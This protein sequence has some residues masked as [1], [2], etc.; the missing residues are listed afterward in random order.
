MNATLTCLVNVLRIIMRQ[1]DNAAGAASTDFLFHERP[2]V[3]ID[4]VKAAIEE[5]V[6]FASRRTCDIGRVNDWG[7]AVVASFFRFVTM[8]CN[9]SRCFELGMT[10]DNLT[11]LIFFS[12]FYS[13]LKGYI[14]IVKVA[15]GNSFCNGGQH[16]AVAF[17]EYLC[18]ILA[19]SPWF[20][21]HMGMTSVEQYE[22]QQCHNKWN[23]RS[24][25][26]F[27]TMVDAEG[28]GAGEPEHDS[29]AVST[30]LRN[31]QKS[32]RTYE[33][34]GCSV[35]SPPGLAMVR[36]NIA[37]TQRS[38]VSSVLCVETSKLIYTQ[39]DGHRKRMTNTPIVDEAK[40]TLLNDGTEKEYAYAAS[41]QGV[42][43]HFFAN[44][45]Y[46]EG[47]SGEEKSLQRTIVNDLT[48]KRATN[49][50]SEGANYPQ[51]LIFYVRSST[52]PLSTSASSNS[53]SSSNASM[54]TDNDEIDLVNGTV[55]ISTG[56][57]L[58][59]HK[60][61]MNLRDV[62]LRDMNA[63]SKLLP[64]LLNA[65]D[66]YS[67]E[68][69]H[70]VN[71]A[72]SNVSR[73]NVLHDDASFV[74]DE[75]SIR[76]IASEIPFTP[77][78]RHL[79]VMLCRAA[80]DDLNALTE[81]QRKLL[82]G[83]MD[84]ETEASGS[85][86]VA[87]VNACLPRRDSVHIALPDA[88]GDIQ[89]AASDVSA[90]S[91]LDSLVTR[92]WDEEIFMNECIAY[93]LHNADNQHAVLVV[94]PWQ[95]RMFLF[96]SSSPTKAIREARAASS[97]T[98][99][100]VYYKA[101]LNF[102]KK[103]SAKKMLSRVGLDDGG[104]E[105][106][107][108]QPWMMTYMPCNQHINPT[109]NGIFAAFNLL[110]VVVQGQSLLPLREE[111][112][113]NARL[114]L[115]H[116][117]A[118]GKIVFPSLIK[119]PSAAPLQRAL[120]QLDPMYTSGHAQFLKDMTEQ[121]TVLEKL[122]TDRH[123]RILVVDESYH[124]SRRTG[125]SIVL[126]KNWKDDNVG[127]V[128]LQRT[129]LSGA[130]CFMVLAHTLKTSP[131]GSGSAG[132]NLT[133]GGNLAAPDAAPSA[134]KRSRAN[135]DLSA[136]A[137]SPGSPG[138]ESSS[139][140]AGPPR[141][142]LK[143]VAMCKERAAAFVDLSM[144]TKRAYVYERMELV[145]AD[146]RLTFATCSCHTSGNERGRVEVR[147]AY[148]TPNCLRAP[149]DSTAQE[150][151]GCPICCPCETCSNRIVAHLELQRS[152]KNLHDASTLYDLVD[153][154]IRQ[155]D[156]GL[157][158]EGF[159]T[160]A[161]EFSKWLGILRT[162]LKD[163]TESSPAVSNA[164]HSVSATNPYWKGALDL[165]D[166]DNDSDKSSSASGSH[167]EGA[168]YG[169]VDEEN[170]RLA[171]EFH[172]CRVAFTHENL[173][174]AYA[175]GFARKPYHLS[176]HS[177]AF[178][179][180]FVLPRGRLYSDRT[181]DASDYLLLPKGS[182][183][184]VKVVH[185]HRGR[186]PVVGRARLA[187]LPEFCLFFC[188]CNEE[189]TLSVRD[190]LRSFRSEIRKARNTTEHDLDFAVRSDTL[191]HLLADQVA[192]FGDFSHNHCTHTS[193]VHQY[194]AVASLRVH[195]GEGR[196]LSEGEQLFQRALLRERDLKL[197]RPKVAARDNMDIASLC[198][199]RQAQAGADI[200]MPSPS[201]R[202]V[203]PP[204]RDGHDAACAC[205]ECAGQDEP[206]DFEDGSDA[207]DEEPEGARIGFPLP[208]EGTAT[209]SYPAFL[210]M[211]NGATVLVYQKDGTN[212]LECTEHCDFSG[213]PHLRLVRNHA[214]AQTDVHK[215]ES[216]EGLN[217]AAKASQF[218]VISQKPR[219]IYI[220][221]RTHEK[222]PAVSSSDAPSVVRRSSDPEHGMCLCKDDL[223][224]DC[225]AYLPG[226]ELIHSKEDTKLAH[227]CKD[228]HVCPACTG[229]EFESS[230]CDGYYYN[231]GTPIPTRV[232]ELHCTREDCGGRVLYD[233]RRN[234]QFVMYLNRKAPSK[235]V[236]IVFS[237][238]FC[239]L[240][241]NLL[242]TSSA[243][244]FH[245]YAEVAA[246]VHPLT[247]PVD[248]E[249]RSRDFFRTA[250]K[251]FHSVVKTGEKPVCSVCLSNPP[252][253]TLDGCRNGDKAIN[254]ESLC[255]PSTLN[256]GEAKTGLTHTEKAYLRVEK[257][258][259]DDLLNFCYS[260]TVLAL[261]DFYD[262]MD[263][264][265]TARIPR[266]AGS[267]A[268]MRRFYQ[269]ECRD[270]NA[271]LEKLIRNVAF[272]RD[273]IVS[274][275]ATAKPFFSS[276][277]ARGVC[278]FVHFSAP[279]TARCIERVRMSIQ[280]A[281]EPHEQ[282]QLLEDLRG[283]L[284]E[285]ESG[286]TEPLPSLDEFR[287]STLLAESE[288]VSDANIK[289]FSD[290][291]T[292]FP[293]LKSFFLACVLRVSATVVLNEANAVRP[294]RRLKACV[295][296]FFRGERMAR[297]AATKIKAYGEIVVHI[298]S[299]ETAENAENVHFVTTTPG[300]EVQ[301]GAGSVKSMRCVN[302]YADSARAPYKITKA[303]ACK[304]ELK[305]EGVA[306]YNFETIT[307][308]CMHGVPYAYM[309]SWEGPE[310]PRRIYQFLRDKITWA[311]KFLCYGTFC[312]GL[313]SLVYDVFPFLL[314]SQRISFI[315]SHISIYLLLVRKLCRQCVSSFSDT[316]IS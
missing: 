256:D 110:S 19:R 308:C 162:A 148:I 5:S 203:I 12:G 111:D 175:T 75:E 188:S 169:D 73:N 176:V 264:L 238:Y 14:G 232:E 282:I 8:A 68:V 229:E 44:V 76:A 124:E 242:P 307:A 87:Y 150:R 187:T 296:L 161:D 184:L 199:L 83:G 303:N 137:R 201:S 15:D 155:Y 4:A 269:V 100:D 132:G 108:R 279:V 86:N 141:H 26:E 248:V 239:N 185:L 40:V 202:Q 278:C 147:H 310:S 192:P 211:R 78:L 312:S 277:L 156:D 316:P 243:H 63:P 190:Y 252:M 55:P 171:T 220:S 88:F 85:E 179:K 38:F 173:G 186:I 139:P 152:L 140:L 223:G 233:G 144:A 123:L 193:I 212:K 142:S 213:C 189:R 267:T 146:E 271:A 66:H 93:L 90:S 217:E 33:G 6:M 200:M 106:L 22:C 18:P 209:F 126:D 253:I 294:F 259:H 254:K 177:D 159:G 274:I 222:R 92:S 13:A 89:N 263:R 249:L 234:L 236:Y 58:V 224:C 304:R 109:S 265:R 136:S 244:T 207:D 183:A 214:R 120:N 96:D 119:A 79:L 246:A 105:K 115:Q 127:V 198:A 94:C 290:L 60:L 221:Y 291:L 262:L 178:S 82:N 180:D 95:K 27:V 311:L 258:L 281:V 116:M 34:D 158:K 118:N 226:C 114:S 245:D 151:R 219:F 42:P 59:F 84:P 216:A 51:T 181:I 315:H 204:L 260:K 314:C 72:I 21:H 122:Q 218:H 237:D 170:A 35:C 145:V 182:P 65:R 292:I 313:Y 241:H 134:S 39:E 25:L 16:M 284:A 101:M 174:E 261:D 30:L 77:R 154:C 240:W 135:A 71:D 250:F 67:E 295:D 130:T 53:S 143:D 45:N 208:P 168:G 298:N 9:P 286:H 133:A 49:A 289:R 164:F 117:F 228:K 195:E 112:V 129:Q 306:D 210:K 257:T 251:T 205:I 91:S 61:S 309:R 31:A 283:L 2:Y 230:I 163:L 293:C 57:P 99:F 23:G 138:E 268:G 196:P 24:M 128:L 97:Q 70:I 104:L 10:R 11:S 231:G 225:D 266:D 191:V 56:N 227:S 121:A 157:E 235:P 52:P 50:Q 7:G 160:H 275:P 46:V 102:L 276:I 273:G 98:P 215:E 297:H 74:V 64:W 62:V 20:C 103:K 287:A 41:V 167:G 69:Q 29:V 131:K 149:G 47:D 80:C 37:V 247:L 272:V 300:E 54:S 255:R 299:L 301:L 32:T 3:E 81:E 194:S 288:D 28:R 36:T 197:K 270:R 166:S 113:P 280:A 48:K 107:L 125:Y 285:S 153:G 172:N 17:Y 165:F 1:E 305:G 302:A 43:G 206:P